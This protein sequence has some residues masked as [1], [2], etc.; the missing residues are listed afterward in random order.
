MLLQRIAAIV[1]AFALAVWIGALA[2]F[3]FV[4]API[5]FGL[6]DLDTFA[7]LA[8]RTISSLTVLGYVCGALA[9]IAA[10]VRSG[11]RA[12]PRVVFVAAA[13]AL[14]AYDARAIVPQMQTI[15]A[16]FHG[17]FDV[18]SK[19]DPRRIAYDDL[20]RRSSEVYGAALLLGLAAI[21][22]AATSEPKVG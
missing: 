7:V 18:V 4:F 20:H 15:S 12:R 8:G 6:T 1:E 10:L 2:G 13:L 16:G 22:L 9:I 19:T 11:A 17:S 3:A 5:A 21:A 14:S